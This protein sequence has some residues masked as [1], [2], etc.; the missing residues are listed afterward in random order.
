MLPQA[1][2]KVLTAASANCIAQA[3]SIAS[4]ASA[5]LNGG[6]VVTIGNGAFG[7]NTTQAVLDTQ[8][9]I[10]IV[11]GGNDS[12]ITAHIYGNRQGGQ[13]INEILALTN[14]GTA[15]S[16]LD[17]LA[18]TKITTSAATATTVTV[19]TNTTGSTDWVLPNYDMGA[20]NLGVATQV[21]GSVT[22]NLETTTT[23]KYFDPPTGINQTT[24]QPVVQTVINAGSLAQTAT[25][26]V[27]VTGFRFTVT[28]GT[29]TLAAQAVQ[30]GITD[31]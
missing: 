7:A 1:L 6:S 26:S 14:A 25:L 5:V 3:Q 27:P 28:A 19:G 4:G 12:A 16:V 24:P 21:T 9:R 31:M 30:S 22:Y 11:S 20:F 10:A 13:P 23:P 8:R 15:V 2:T 17:Y 18:V 29:G